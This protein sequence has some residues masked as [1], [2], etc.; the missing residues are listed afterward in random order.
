MNNSIRDYLINIYDKLSH[1]STLLNGIALFKYLIKKEFYLD[2]KCNYI[3]KELTEQTNKLNGEDKKECLILLPYFFINQISLKYLT[4]IL[5][6]LFTQINHTTEGIFNPM[7]KIFADILIN[8]QNLENQNNYIKML[9]NNNN[10]YEKNNNVYNNNNY[11][12]ILLRLCLDLIDNNNLNCFFKSKY[13]DFSLENYQ[14]KCG[15]LFLGQ[16]IEHYNN[17]ENDQRI[18]NIIINI[19]KNNFSFLKNKNFAAKKEYL[20]CINILINKLKKDFSIYAKDL[21]NDIYI[22]DKTLSLANSSHKPKSNDFIELKKSLLDI[23]YSL[24]LYNRD[25]ISDDYKKILTYAKINKS[26][27]NKDIRSISIKIIDI[28]IKDNFSTNIN[29]NLN[30]YNSNDLDRNAFTIKNKNLKDRAFSF[31]N[32]ESL[33]KKMINEDKKKYADKKHNKNFIFVSQNS[34]YDSEQHP[35]PKE[36]YFTENKKKEENAKNSEKKEKKEKSKNVNNLNVVN[37]KIHEIRNMNDNMIKTV[38]NIEKNLNNNFNNIENKLN[39]I[40]KYEESHRKKD[41]NV[42]YKKDYSNNNDIK[43]NFLD[44]KIKNIILNDEKLIEFLEEISDKEINNISILYFEQIIN[45]LMILNLINKNNPS[46]AKTYFGLLQKLLDCKK[47]TDNEF[48]NYGKMKNNNNRK[49]KISYNLENNLN[50][51]FN[52]LNN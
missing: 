8:V 6:I 9:K 21:L 10:L 43:Q 12:N 38:N 49:Y 4:K 19:L 17:I 48:N 34:L 42:Y 15:Y 5:N 30:N 52:S 1:K 14:Q 29:I 39:K 25:E 7:A 11:E 24:L 28:I 20:L 3:I 16:F 31:K 32:R 27:P 47:I 51:L 26:D 23:I 46:Q 37:L 13:H 44:E 33:I 41:K 40:V 22:F 50:Y 36:N 18:L 35:D 2:D 45:R